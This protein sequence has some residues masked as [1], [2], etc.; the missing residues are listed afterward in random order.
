M[1]PAEKVVGLHLF[2]V[3]RCSQFVVQDLMLFGYQSR[4]EFSLLP[5][6]IDLLP[7]AQHHTSE[8]GIETKSMRWSSWFQGKS[9]HGAF[10]EQSN[11]LYNQRLAQQAPQPPAKY[12]T[13]LT[14]CAP[15]HQL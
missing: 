7:H 5:A 15:C 12:V 10:S 4:I 3:P 2:I 14:A 9:T 1:F 8:S 13:V 11:T 6:L